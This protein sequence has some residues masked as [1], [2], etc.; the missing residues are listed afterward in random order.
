[1]PCRRPVN[2]MR[3]AR[4]YDTRY[5]STICGRPG[6]ATG[7]GVLELKGRIL[8][9]QYSALVS[10]ASCPSDRSLLLRGHGCNKQ[11][12]LVQFVYIVNDQ[13]LTA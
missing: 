13:R 7:D 5:E 6:T 9:R 8:I 10:H 2:S 4:R 11:L 12:R 1:M 3:E